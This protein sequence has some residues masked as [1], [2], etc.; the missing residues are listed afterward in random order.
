MTL[1]AP[2]KVNLTLEVIGKRADG[3]H[4]LR[5]VFQAVDLF[6]TLRFESSSQLTLSV[7]GEAPPDDDNLVLKAARAL[8]AHA[9]LGTEP[10]VA[11]QLTKRI[12]TG[13]GLGGGSS[14]AAATLMALDRLWNTDLSPQQLQHIARDLGADVPFFLN[15]GT[16][17]GTGR[18]DQ[19]T[20]VHGA[21]PMWFVI[22]MPPYSLPAKTAR[23]FRGL[24]ADK[25]T[26]GAITGELVRQLTAGE[27]PSVDGC[28]N[29]LQAAAYREFGE[30]AGYVADLR[31]AS[32]RE[33][34]LSGAGP[35]CFTITE[36]EDESEEVKRRLENRSG[37]SFV[38]HACGGIVSWNP[39]P[40]F[41]HER[42]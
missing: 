1:L 34:V 36:S 40:R 6:D 35:A 28:Y 33:W 16:A 29:G 20:P 15:G 4:E 5:T 11:I 2:A 41:P 3:Y 19:I 26:D 25:Y 17:L 9:T 10:G 8:R 18:G 14:D 7:A 21:P 32:G 23:I 37:M 22:A 31:R 12:P 13:A 30:L 39:S 42:A 27:H 24:R 38:A